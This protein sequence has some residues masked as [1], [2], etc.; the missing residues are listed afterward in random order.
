MKKDS[1]VTFRLDDFVDDIRK[2]MAEKRH[3]DFPILD[4]MVIMWE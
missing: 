2:V 3:R 1:L 4:N